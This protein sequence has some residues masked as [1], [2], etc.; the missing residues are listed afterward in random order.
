MSQTARHA[1][2]VLLDIAGF[3][4]LP[5]IAAQRAVIRRLQE[6]ITR[7]AKPFVGYAEPW[8][9]MPRHGTG[10]GYF[11]T[12]GAFPS[13]VALRFAL[14]LQQALVDDNPSHADFP[15]RLR[16]ALTLGDVESVQDQ[17]LSAAFIEAARL[18]DQAQVKALLERSPPLALVAAPL[19][20]D[21]WRS[22]PARSDEGLRVPNDLPWT[23]VEFTDKHGKRWP[24]YVQVEERLFTGEASSVPDA[25]PTETEE[26]PKR[27]TLLIGH[28]LRD[29]LPEAVEMAT[30]TAR[31]WMNSGLRVELRVDQATR[32][33]LKIAARLGMDLLIFYGHGD[34]TGRLVFA[35][36]DLVGVEDLREDLQGLELFLV[37]ACHGAT[38]A[39]GL[40]CPWIA[41]VD[42]IRRHA[43]QGFVESWIALLGR[44]GP[45]QSLPQTME[46]CRHHMSSEFL[47]QLRN[48]GNLPTQPWLSGEPRLLHGS[49]H[50]FGRACTDMVTTRLGRASYV[51]H[52]PFAGR[53][54]LLQT[55]VSLPDPRTDQER[56]RGIW[57]HGDAGIGKSAL[58]RQFTAWIEFMACDAEGAPIH[59]IQMNCWDF[60]RL[61]DLEQAFL[62]TLAKCYRRDPAPTTLNDLFKALEPLP[63]R[64]VWVLDDLSYLTDGSGDETGPGLTERLMRHDAGKQLVETLLEGARRAALTLQLVVSARRPGPGGWK[65][66]PLQPLEL[67]EARELAQEVLRRRWPESQDPPPASSLTGAETIFHRVGGSTALY[68]RALFLACDGGVGFSKYADLMSRG[69]AAREA[70]DLAQEMVAFEAQQ[71]RKLEPR[72]HF[73]FGRFLELCYALVVRAGHFT[74]SELEKWFGETLCLKRPS[75]QI[76]EIY[77]EALTYLANIGF[78]A[79]RPDATRSGRVWILPPNQRLP[80]RVLGNAELTLPEG[81]PQRGA[82]ERLA[83][84]LEQAASKRSDQILSAIAEFQELEND[85]RPM[86]HEPEP[87]TAVFAAMLVRAELARLTPDTTVD[88]PIYDEMVALYDQHRKGYGTE[89]AVAAEQVASALVNKGVR[90][91]ALGR[92]EEEMGVYDAL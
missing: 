37:F 72:H 42:P 30:A 32:V 28:S 49:P 31:A 92:G 18:I 10:D 82:R 8:Q 79:D 57:I 9:V 41:F 22:H 67:S 66:H 5:N 73:A 20:L 81:I 19:F 24:G 84:A 55:L 63:G 86:I 4:L 50:L 33:N 17:L 69:P 46:Q 13:P 51:A 12:L 71:L 90:L 62:K 47:D 83:L 7:C 14:D 11:I 15:L 74:T 54:R 77:D 40:S 87:A 53:V 65:N 1:P 6:L 68:K 23:R 21:D 38:F 61:S 16:V 52:D 89:D 25:A 56:R 91:G 34:E 3:D 80:L 26:T 43:P 44:L 48:S 64:H 70:G 45:A 39:G 88:L 76:G 36:D 59:L 2:I 29:P 58:V 85:Y 27:V 60:S 78:L 75:S 35:D